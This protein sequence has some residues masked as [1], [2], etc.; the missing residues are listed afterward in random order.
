M[1]GAVAF[2]SVGELGSDLPGS[3]GHHDGLDGVD[4]RLRESLVFG[5]AK[6]RGHSRFASECHGC[7]EV[8]QHG[9]TFIEDLTASGGFVELVVPLHLL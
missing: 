2:A 7:T 4:F 1:F 6:V 5:H 8:K 3:D 9:G